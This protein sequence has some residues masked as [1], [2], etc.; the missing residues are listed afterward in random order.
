M[1]AGMLSINL[2]F[3]P[4]TWLSLSEVLEIIV[5]NK[6]RHASCS[7]EFWDLGMETEFEK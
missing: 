1:R 3:V 4:P 5:V 6:K 2:Y 7:G